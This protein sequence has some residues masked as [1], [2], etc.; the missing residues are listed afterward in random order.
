MYSESIFVSPL[1]IP[2]HLKISSSHYFR[3]IGSGANYPEY[4]IGSK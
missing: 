4:V 2:T 1:P 3:T